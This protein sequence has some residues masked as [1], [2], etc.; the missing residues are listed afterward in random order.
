MSGLGFKLG[1]PGYVLPVRSRLLST[2][3]K[4][5]ASGRQH[6]RGSAAFDRATSFVVSFVEVLNRLNIVAVIGHHVPCDWASFLAIR[7][8]CFLAIEAMSA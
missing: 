7:S 2:G 5:A 6:M 8:S 1:L 4:V 3:Q